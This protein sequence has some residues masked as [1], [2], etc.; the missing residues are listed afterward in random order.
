MPDML[1]IS[2]FQPQFLVK[3]LFR[4]SISPINCL[5]IQSR[6]QH[7]IISLCPPLC[8]WTCPRGTPPLVF[9]TTTWS[10]CIHRFIPEP[11]DNTETNPIHASIDPNSRTWFMPSINT[12]GLHFEMLNISW[13]VLKSELCLRLKHMMMNQ[14]RKTLTC[15]DDTAWKAPGHMKL[16]CDVA[17]QRKNTNLSRKLEKLNPL[18]LLCTS[19]RF[20]VFIMKSQLSHIRLSEL[21]ITSIIWK[22]N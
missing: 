9:K 14:R 22:K 8:L 6:R 4:F 13:H 10:C 21:I 17:T 5:S 19:C 18:I 15:C 2:Q 7:W 1:H 3:N 12:P 11:T 20:T 16:I